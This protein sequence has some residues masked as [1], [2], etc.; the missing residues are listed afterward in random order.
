MRRGGR[1]VIYDVGDDKKHLKLP[2]WKSNDYMDELVG[3]LKRMNPGIAVSDLRHGARR[4]SQV[5][6]CGKCENMTG[7]AAGFRDS[8]YFY[9]LKVTMSRCLLESI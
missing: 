9:I 7:M 6:A 5:R 3:E 1:Y 4:G 2:T 8:H